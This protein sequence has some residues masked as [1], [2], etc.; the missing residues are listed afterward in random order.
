MHLL[1]HSCPCGVR[2]A[3]KPL[4]G[5]R[6]SVKDNFKVA[7]I[8]TTQSN[9]AFVETYGP[10][11]ETAR[12]LERLVDLGAIL[13]GKTKMCAFASSE[14]ATDQW[15]GFH[16][17]FNPRA[18]GY[19]SPSGSTTGGAAALA[20]DSWLDFSVETDKRTNMSI[21]E[22]WAQCPPDEASGKDIREYLNKTAYY[23]FYYDGYNEFSQFRK[24]HEDKFGKPA[25]V[26]PYMRWKWYGNVSSINLFANVV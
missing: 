14:E 18:D 17:P 11:Q 19:Q 16:A 21:A 4:A 2:R 9:R 13:V 1:R 20:A 5:K 26:G 24:D 10:E 22:R 8:K 7:G 12:F 3:D 15:I 23:P 25:Y 6:I